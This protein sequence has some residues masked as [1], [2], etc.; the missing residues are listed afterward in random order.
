MR[1]KHKGQGEERHLMKNFSVLL[2]K[3]TGTKICGGGKGGTWKSKI[4]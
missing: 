1:G 3:E 2:G 4:R